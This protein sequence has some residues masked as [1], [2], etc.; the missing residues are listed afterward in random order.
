MSLVTVLVNRDCGHCLRA[1]EQV[2]DLARRT[3]ASV[4]ATDITVHPE[5]CKGLQIK[6]SP[7]VLFEDG[8]AYPGVP[9]APTFEALTHT[10]AA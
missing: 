4:A 2:E 7:A 6:R 10:S 8:V 5:V 3:G 9:D 1:I